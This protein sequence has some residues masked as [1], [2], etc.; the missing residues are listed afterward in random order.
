VAGT[1]IGLDVLIYEF[2]DG[3]SAEEILDLYP[4]IG[5]LAKAYGAIAFILEH[6]KEIATYLEG[7]HRNY[8]E[9]KTANPLS[10]DMIERFE[11]GKRELPAQ[12]S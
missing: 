11:R 9:F 12:Q 1:R 7:Q 4:S 2:Q 8:E 6:S 5:S 3:R 10:P